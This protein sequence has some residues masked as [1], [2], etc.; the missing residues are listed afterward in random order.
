MAQWERD[1]GLDSLRDV[2]SCSYTRHT[3]GLTAS[4]LN[5]LVIIYS[6]RE[7]LCELNLR[8]VHPDFA[9]GSTMVPL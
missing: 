2:S 4:V 6:R 9:T 5:K 8:G 1:R 7:Y 3:Y